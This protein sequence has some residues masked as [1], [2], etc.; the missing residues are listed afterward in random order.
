MDITRQNYA[1]FMFKA[2]PLLTLA[3][4]FQAYI[5]FKFAPPEIAKEVVVFLGLAL[6]G[7]FIFYFIYDRFHKVI[8]NPTSLEIRFDPLQ[9][10]YECSYREI[11]D[12]QIKSGKNNYHHVMIHLES[13]KVIRLANVDDAHRIKQYLLERN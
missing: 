9:F 2:M 11:V 12:V 6:I 3:Y 7:I 13:G 10:H 4:F 1:N 8:L 5:Y